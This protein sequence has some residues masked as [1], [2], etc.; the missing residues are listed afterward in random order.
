MNK[1]DIEKKLQSMPNV[2]KRHDWT[3][4]EDD[5]ILKYYRDKGAHAIAALIA[6]PHGAVYDRY[7]LLTEGRKR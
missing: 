4:D 1:K 5:I 6:K 7:K 2:K 3:K